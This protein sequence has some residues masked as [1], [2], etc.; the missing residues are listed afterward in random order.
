MFNLDNFYK[1]IAHLK[2]NVEYFKK[3][4]IIMLYTDKYCKT[5]HTLN[6]I[7]QNVQLSFT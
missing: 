7:F 6:I 5:R 4:N 3:Y 1:W 2:S